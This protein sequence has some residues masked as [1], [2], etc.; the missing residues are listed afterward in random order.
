MFAPLVNQ[1]RHRPVIEI[2]ETATN[3]R[4]SFAG[5]IDHRRGK[6]ELRVQPRF[7]SVLIGRSDVGEMICHQRTDMTG[8]ELRRQELIGPRSLQSGHK[9][10]SDDRSENDRGGESQP[11]P[12]VPQRIVRGSGCLLGNS[13]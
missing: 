12:D 1:R 2:I 4:K 11:I 6:I 7:D 9:G 8:D 13:G 10:E 3:Q 5:K